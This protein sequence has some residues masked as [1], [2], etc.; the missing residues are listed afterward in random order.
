MFDL[1]KCRA[2]Q[3]LL[4]HLF[5]DKLLDSLALRSQP[6]GGAELDDLGPFLRLEV[7]RSRPEAAFPSA[8]NLNGPVQVN[9]LHRALQNVSPVFNPAQIVLQSLSLQNVCEVSPRGKDVVGALHA[10]PALIP[11]LE[12]RGVLGDEVVYWV[13]ILQFLSAYVFSFLFSCLTGPAVMAICLKSDPVAWTNLVMLQQ[14]SVTGA[15]QNILLALPF[16]HQR[17]RRTSAESRA[18]RDEFLASCD[19]GRHG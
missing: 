7:V 12:A 13:H 16:L 1:R 4:L 14:P 6:S 19:R 8:A 2:H 18:D 5:R 10:A 17:N 9:D 3:Q 15:G 11:N